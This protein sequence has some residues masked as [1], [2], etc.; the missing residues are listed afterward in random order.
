MADDIFVWLHHLQ[1]V[2][3]RP[4]TA[5]PAPATPVT[6]HKRACNT[7]AH[8]Q[9]AG[10]KEKASDDDDMHAEEGTEET[11]M[12]DDDDSEGAGGDAAGGGDAQGANLRGE[13]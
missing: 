11:L 1:N 9:C 8:S 12:P 2:A 5:T 3:Q 10:G 13:M 4:V 7:A 6:L